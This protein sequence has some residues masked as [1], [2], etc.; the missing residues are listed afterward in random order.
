MLFVSY[1]DFIAQPAFVVPMIFEALEEP[2]KSAEVIRTLA[3]QAQ[4]I[5]D[6]LELMLRMA[7]DKHAF[8]DIERL[9]RETMHQATQQIVQ[10][11]DMAK[12]LEVAREHRLVVGDRQ[13]IESLIER[14]HQVWLLT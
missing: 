14:A 7:K 2:G 4:S 10:R 6:W 12:S 11:S 8:L 9:L 5:A 13:K 1:H 3:A